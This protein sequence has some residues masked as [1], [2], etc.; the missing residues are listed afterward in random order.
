MISYTRFIDTPVGK[1]LLESDGISLTGVYFSVQ[2]KEGSRFQSRS[3]IDVPEA[4]DLLFKR[5]QIQ[6]EQYFKGERKSFDLDINLCGTE[7]QKKVWG[8]L[9]KIPFGATITYKELA[10]RTG[11][12]RAQRAVGF[13]NSKNPISLIVPCHR[14]IGENGAL[15]GYAGGLSNKEYLLRL[16]GAK[17][18]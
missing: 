11:N 2:L 12:P 1:I 10:I 6:I 14:V 16:E 15:T 4:C 3:Q 5:A 18:N 13:A 8:E 17:N 7:F 9:C